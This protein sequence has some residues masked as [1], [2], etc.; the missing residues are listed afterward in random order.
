MHTRPASGDRDAVDTF[1]T[2]V[3]QVTDLGRVSEATK[4]SAFSSSTDGGEPPFHRWWAP[5]SPSLVDTHR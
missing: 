2:P 3:F 1:V 4:G 5:E